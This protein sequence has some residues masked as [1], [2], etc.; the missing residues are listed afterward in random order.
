MIFNIEKIPAQTGK[1]AIV[2][3]ANNGI[4]FETTKALARKEVEVVMACRN[5]DKAAEAK[6]NI[7]KGN[8]KAKLHII[9][10]DLSKM[11][12]VRKFAEEFTTKYN[13]LDFLINNAGI[14]MPPFKLTEDGFESQL[15][16][17]YLGHF[18][19]TKLVFP[20][21]KKTEN[22]RIV[23][24]SSLAHIWHE[25]QFDDMNFKK[26]Y[27]KRYAYSQSKLACLMF[28]IE[29]DRRLKSANINAISA[30]AH[31]GV[32]DTNLTNSMPKIFHFIATR[33]GSLLLQSA[34]DG[35]KPTLYAALGNDINGGDYTGPDGKGEMKGEAKKVKPRKMA[36]K[37]DITEQLWSKTEEMLG[38][39]FEVA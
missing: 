26:S 6:A 29:L 9:E 10:L 28:G 14:M 13:R 31:P 24:L 12:S 37:S 5:L 25:I 38:E 7:L 22:A 39:K 30:T 11:S 21:I 32:S 20:I 4:G 17:N 19:L 23:S 3:G 35:A 33:V 27:N 8:K 36:Q 16:T 18:L 15:A 1:V 34:A 2:T